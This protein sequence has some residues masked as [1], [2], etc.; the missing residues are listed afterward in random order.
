MTVRLRRRDIL[1]GSLAAAATALPHPLVARGEPVR[2]G[3][4]T[5]KTGPLAQGGIQME[6]GITVFLRQRNQRLAGRKVELI[7]A[8]T[9]G[10][11]AGA[12][13]KIRELIE[14]DN[15]DLVLGPLADFELLAISNYVAAQKVLILPHAGTDKVTQREPNPFVIRPAA[16]ASQRLF[17][18]GDYA[19]RELKFKSVITIADDFAFGYEQI[20]GFQKVFEDNGGR[21]VK[22]LWAPLVTPDYTP[23][24]AQI[25]DADAVVAGFAGSNPLKFMKQYASL[26]LTLPI[27]GG[28]AVGDDALL[29]AYGDET[30]GMINVN[31]YT[32][33]LD[34]AANKQFVT[35]MVTISGH[36]PG[37]YA[38]DLYLQGM[39][40]EAALEKT[41]G[42]TAEKS[43]LREA[44]R[45]VSLTD[46]PCG[47]LRFDHLGQ[48]IM[49]IYVRHIERSISGPFQSKLANKTVKVYPGVMQFWTY[50]EQEYLAQ[51]PYS[52]D[53][54]PL[55]S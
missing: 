3:L 28:Q 55:R 2:L 34:S 30:I 18:L 26:G 36:R 5:V 16:T 6:Q 38:A 23:Y 39:V 53:Y 41:G 52:R 37:Y 13:T 15:V 51:Q 11:P 8:D 31:P 44:L 24:L 54:P 7:I 27:L 9:G 25:G 4:L 21:I 10:S 46:S 20:G 50:S 43:R 40:V 33:D 42:D 47:P 49:N 19:A 1:A 22:K 32:A 48:G 29:H 45:S 14:R 35:D 17:P 12:T